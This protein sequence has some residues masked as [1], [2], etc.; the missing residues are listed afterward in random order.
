MDDRRTDYGREASEL[1]AEV[2]EVPQ[3]EQPM[4]REVRIHHTLEK[5]RQLITGARGAGFRHA[6]NNLEHYLKGKGRRLIM[7][8]SAFMGEKF[9][10]DHLRNVH[11]S[12]FA[13][14]AERRLKS[15]DLVIGGSVHMSSG[16]DPVITPRESKLYFA[17]GGFS[18]KSKVLVSATEI[19]GDQHSALIRFKR[20]TV[21]CSDYYD[22]HPGMMTDVPF[23]GT[24][25]DEEM[26][27]LERTG[28]A[29][30]Y[31]IESRSIVALRMLGPV[32]IAVQK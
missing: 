6:A 3:T 32:E 4:D 23:F 10:I 22:W 11:L 7:P 1:P 12:E 24:I 25:E 17:L 28:I 26:A 9:L 21:K 14:G 2:T 27:E 18:V 13:A 29:K 16:P 31:P 20:W 5:V 19:Q 15:G 8:S 30:S